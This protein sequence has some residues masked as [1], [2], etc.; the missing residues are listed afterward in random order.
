MRKLRLLFISALMAVPVVGTLGSPA[1]AC[2]SPIEPDGCAVVNRVC[3]RLV[4]G[5]CLG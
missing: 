2:T 4:G 1:R 3:R 5:D